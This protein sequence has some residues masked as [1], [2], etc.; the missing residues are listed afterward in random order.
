MDKANNKPFKVTRWSM[1]SF[2]VLLNSFIIFYSCLDDKTTNNW[3]RFV[4]NI[5]TNIVNTFTPS[6]TVNIPVTSVETSFTD[7]EINNIPGYQEDE[8]PLGS[9]KEIN[10]VVLPEN[11]TIKEVSYSEVGN[12]R[13]T[14]KLKQDGSKAT[15]IGMRHGL[16]TVEANCNNDVFS[17]TEV[18][19]MDL[20]APL[21]FDASIEN[22][23][24]PIGGAETI[25]VTITNAFNDELKDSLYYDV[26]KLTYSSDNDA[27][28]TVG[29]YGVITPVSEGS[30]TIR[31]SN[32]QGIEKSFNITVSGNTPVPSYTNLSIEGNDYC[33]EHD[34]FS[35]KKISLTIKDNDVFLD[36][37]EFIWESS[38]PVLARVNQKGEVYG[39][40]KSILEDESVLITATNKRTQQVVAKEIV[41]KKELPTTMYTVYRIGNKDA[42]SHPKVTAF[43]GDA[44]AVKISYD[45]TVINPTV[46][47]VSS[48]EE[49]VEVINQN[50]KVILVFHKEG[51]SNITITSDLVPTLTDTTEVTVTTGG[52]INQD[53]Y[54]D[55]NLSIR[56]SIGHALLFGITQVFTFLALYMFFPDRKWWITALISLGA[57]ILLASVSEIIQAFIPLRSGAFLDVLVDLSG[58][59]IALAITV[60]ILLLIKNH[61]NKKE[62]KKTE[63]KINE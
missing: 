6:Q 58:V 2:A 37:N 15:L 28:A 63:G 51:V 31:V 8:I 44:M 14:I 47:A 54:E 35:K 29:R 52:V 33:Y 27:I 49:V 32:P 18:K 16:T 55:V 1:L 42:W 56:K 4:S 13:G 23:T 30:T 26:S 46:T 59:V 45:K 22:N 25:K 43:V 62:S 40:R 20:I 50:D 24:I 5:F 38:N 39:Y 60:G 34:I 53:N 61:K 21:S 41:I 7:N 57:G 12:N 36:N 19:V 48:N 11:A 10:T 3:N 9:E 17:K